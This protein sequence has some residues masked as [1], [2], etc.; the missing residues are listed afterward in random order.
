MDFNKDL[1]IQ[2]GIIDCQ[3]D[4]LIEY[5]NTDP[6][7][8]KFTSDPIRFKNRQSFDQWLNKGRIIY[9]L[10]DK[11]KNLLGIIW[12]G[13]KSPPIKIEANFTFAIRLYSSARGQGFS[14]KF[15][16]IV[17]N[18]LL[19]EKK[20]V[21]ALWLDTEIENS[22]AIHTYEKFGFKKIEEKNNRVVM[23]LNL[24]KIAPCL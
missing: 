10:T 3:I 11:A 19:K 23:A 22:V 4:Q 6:Q 1:F 9:T 21:I 12:F 20:D 13:K 14:Q 16:N 2:Q 7:V 15:M 8:E 18:D 24:D 5:S 17:F